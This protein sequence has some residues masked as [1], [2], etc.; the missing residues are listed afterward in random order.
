[1]EIACLAFAIVVIILE[2][3]YLN[4]RVDAIARAL[5]EQT[6]GSDG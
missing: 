6:G 4:R 2:L 3:R 1:M 5:E